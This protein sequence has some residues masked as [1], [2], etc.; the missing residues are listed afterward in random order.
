[1]KRDMDLI[2]KILFKIEEEFPAGQLLLH[3]INI[4]GYDMETVAD[5]CQLMYESGLINDYRPTRGGKGASVLF[6]SIGNLTNEGYDLLDK[7][8]EDTIWNNTKT[9]ITEKG[10]PLV[11]DVIKDVSSTIISSMVEGVIKGV[12]P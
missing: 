1:M 5:H 6:Y 2:R 9:T 12:K 4:E 3:C 8:R 10:L 7:I 11:I